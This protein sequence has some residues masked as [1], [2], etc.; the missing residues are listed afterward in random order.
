MYL[1]SPASMRLALGPG[2]AVLILGPARV[3]V[4]I[5]SSEKPVVSCQL[6]VVSSGRPLNG[7]IQSPNQVWEDQGLVATKEVGTRLRGQHCQI[8]ARAHQEV[9]PARGQMRVGILVAHQQAFLNF[10]I[11]WSEEPRNPHWSMVVSH[12]PLRLQLPVRGRT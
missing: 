10:I 3:L 8:T 1:S 11:A 6:L 7:R 9:Q 12:R 2:S 5:G 4:V